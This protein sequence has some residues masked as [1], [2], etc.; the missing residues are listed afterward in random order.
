MSSPRFRALSSVLGVVAYLSLA[1]CADRPSPAEVGAPHGGPASRAVGDVFTV[2]SATDGLAGSLRAVMAQTTGG[3]VIHFDPSLAGTKITLDTTLDI[4]KA[5]TIEGPADKG[6]IISGGGK[7]TVFNIK[8]GA[9]LRN[10]TITQGKDI[11]LLASAIL[12][13]GPLLLDHV[14]VS[15]NPMLLSAVRGDNISLTNSTVANN[16]GQDGTIAVFKDPSLAPLL[17]ANSTIAFNGGGIRSGEITF[18]NAIIANNGSTGNLN[19]QTFSPDF[20]YIGKTILGDG[21]CAG[22]SLTTIVADP[23]LLPLADNGGPTQTLALSSDSPA[24]NA[25]D[26]PGLSVDQRYVPRDAKCDIGAFE[27]VFTTVALTIDPNGTVDPKTGVATITGTMTCSRAETFD[28]AVDVKQDQRL[29]RALTTAS[30][31]TTIH[32]GCDATPKPWIASVTAPS[33]GF[34]NSVAAVN[35]QT[36]NTTIGVTPGATSGAVQLSW[37]RR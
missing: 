35:V 12:S 9:T 8:A 27:F 6:V 18:Q 16:S 10:L 34:E 32:V 1:A 13:K 14:T 36:A 4:P 26:C 17:I 22:S 24:I 21:V 37:A 2:T 3:E 20:T 25:T 33:G 29:R 30:G 28:L 5:V 11:G 31:K 15:G 7:A 19:C 23:K